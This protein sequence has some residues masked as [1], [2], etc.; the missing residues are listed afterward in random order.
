ML[1]TI[2]MILFFVAIGIAAV[3]AFKAFAYK[4]QLISYGQNVNRFD[5]PG[6]RIRTMLKRVLLQQCAYGRRPVPGFFHSMIFWGFLVFVLVTINHVLEGFF[7]HFS[8]FGHGPIYQAVIFLANFFAFMILIAVIFFAVRRYVFRPSTLE[9]PS[10]E[11]L[12]ILSFITILMISF[13]FYEAFRMY[14]TPGVPAN[15]VSLWV[16]NHLMPPPDTIAP[17]TITT[18]IKTLWW[19]HILTVMAFG[20]F[21]PYS[22]HLHLIAGPINIL[23]KNNRTLAEIPVIDLEKAAEAEKLGTPHISDFTRK[24]LL[25]LFS[26]AQCGRCDDVCPALNSGKDLSPKSLLDKFK[27]HLFDSAPTLA[28]GKDSQVDLKTLFAQVISEKE[29]WDCTT[30]GACMQ[31]CPMFNEHIPKIMGMR[32]YAVMMESNFP[33][34]FNALFRGLENQG[35]PWGISAQTRTEWTEGLD[36]PLIA[37]KD[38]TDLLL[39]VGCEGSFDAH[40][41]KNTRAFVQLL[42]AAQVDF[43]IL[44]NDEKCCGD[45]ARRNGQEYLYQLLATENIELIKSF[46]G[47]FNRIVTMCPH[48][49][50]VLKH[51]YPQL[52]PGFDF[53]VIHYS[54]LIIELIHSRQLKLKT[55]ANITPTFHDPCYLG[56]YNQEYQ[57]PRQIIR[58]LNTRL[59]EMKN[60]QEASSCCGAGGGGMWKEESKGQRI[61]HV[62]IKQAQNTGADTIVTACPF[63]SVMFKDA[64]AETDTPNLKTI[65]LAQLVLDHCHT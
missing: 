37:N 9:I 48:G 55:P 29:V 27:N 22:K 24:D 14:A 4:F 52:D 59:K 33:E 18:W 5:N 63:C 10:F 17:H 31:A 6:T 20:V 47:K 61:S 46:K 51:E 39:W 42:K 2:E 1:S 50:H 13:F 35:N 36:V 23:F 56:R 44:G 45:P 34:E 53:P 43:A 40:N 64:I 19:V 8:L 57:A 11:S 3:V 54:Q 30:C 38:H 62:R 21:I 41:Q 60:S 12:I 32:Q 58:A 25:D 49:L 65:D 28:K 7:N 15:F 16:F 26:C